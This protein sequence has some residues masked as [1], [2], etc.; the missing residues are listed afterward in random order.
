MCGT[1]QPWRNVFHDKR[2]EP[3][4]FHRLT[5][6]KSVL[7][8]PDGFVGHQGDFLLRDIGGSSSRDMMCTSSFLFITFYHLFFPKIYF[9]DFGLPLRDENNRWIKCRYQDITKH[10]PENFALELRQH[11]I[12]PQVL[13]LQCLYQWIYWT[14]ITIIKKRKIESYKVYIG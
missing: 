11:G 2:T 5:R 14:S 9:E 4:P 1:E 6:C 13:F 8:N 3:G 7:D 12:N 10:I